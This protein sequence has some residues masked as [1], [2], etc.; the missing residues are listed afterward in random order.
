[1]LTYQETVSWMFQQLPMYQQLGKKASRADLSNITK[2]VAHLENP[3]HNLKMIH[4]AGTNGKGSVS[5]M[6]ASVLQESGYKVGLYTSP[7]L[8]DFKER[9]RVNGQG[10]SE[11][12]VIE[13]IGRNRNFLEQEN[14]SFFEMTVGM[15]FDYFARE[16]TDIAVI[17]VGLGG[18]LDS[19]NIIDPVLAVI[20]NIGFDHV[21]ILGHSLP[22]IAREKAG[23]I[24]KG[25]PVVV[26]EILP[27][28]LPVFQEVA[29]ARGARLYLAPQD[30]LLPDSDLKGYYQDRNKATALK[31]IE[32][33]I[34]QG[35]NIPSEAVAKGFLHVRENTGLRGRWDVLQ[36]KPRVIG[37]TAHNAEGLEYVLRQLY[38]Q[39]YKQLYIVLGVVSDK[40]LDAI[41]PLFP[42]EAC[43]FFCKPAVPRGLQEEVLQEKASQYG[44]RGK[45]FPSVQKALEAALNVAEEDDL[46]YVGG[47]TCT[48]AEII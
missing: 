33:L 15:A 27:E 14:Y 13:F 32:V 3:H 16:E 39:E 48:V 4:V 12:A 21:G 26:G 30:S 5:H 29:A 2:L 24:K 17:E 8:K 42:K 31:A 1:M 18:R 47:S 11:E 10:I 7:H 6:L 25:R 46:I 19:T 22:E 37:D 23:I 40:D 34:D 44:L 38:D 45:I 43:Y 20:T 28:T 36:E 9:I 35:W 41:L